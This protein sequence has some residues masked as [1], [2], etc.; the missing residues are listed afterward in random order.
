MWGGGGGRAD[1]WPPGGWKEL[2]TASRAKKEFLAGGCYEE[3]L[4]E[5]KVVRLV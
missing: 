3:D 5:D 1:L 4:T 2:K